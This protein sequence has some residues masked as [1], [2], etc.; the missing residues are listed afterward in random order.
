MF[1]EV[2]YRALT[3]GSPKLGWHEYSV[4]LGDPLEDDPDLVTEEIAA[5]PAC[6]AQGN[7]S[8]GIRIS[9]EYVG[10]ERGPLDLRT[11][12][13]ERLGVGKWWN[14]SLA[15]GRVISREAWAA[16]A[17]PDRENRI[18][19]GHEFGVDVNPD[20]SWGSVAIAGVRGDGLDQFA[21]V[22]RRRRTD[23]I[24]DR[25]EE[26]SLEHPGVSFVV[27]ARGP[28]ANL[29]PEMEE[30]GL[31]V[32]AAS[33]ADYG[34]ACSDFFDGIDHGTAR[35]PDP[36]PEL[37][38]ALA[39]ARKSTGQENAWTWSRKAST[40]PDISPLVAVTLA[41][42]GARTQG[43]PNV[44]SLAEVLAGMTAEASAPVP[45]AAVPESPELPPGFVPLDAVPVRRGLFRP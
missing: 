13:V 14:P 30:R 39:G 23:W 20:R 4:D 26:L 24:V 5:D 40:S 35:Y 41:L 7:P 19:S 15:G 6:W 38:D 18:E 37:D 34:V 1:S 36:Q 12:A 43:P 33:G 22:D 44:W 21:V 29:I 9:H 42:W 45:E 11:F 25:C 3:G 10:D 8:L 28:A 32:V 31:V 27:L 16:C 2:R 17:E